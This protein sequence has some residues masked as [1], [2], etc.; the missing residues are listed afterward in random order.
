MALILNTV[1]E[2]RIENE[3]VFYAKH[4]GCLVYKFNSPSNRS[5]PDRLFICPNGE[6][7]FIEFK[8]KGKVPTTM[9]TYTIEKMKERGVDV[10]VVDNIK[11]GKKVIDEWLQSTT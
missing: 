5:V 2:K 11:E 6:I 10:R 8:G 1:M 4:R 9:Q 7:K 3:V